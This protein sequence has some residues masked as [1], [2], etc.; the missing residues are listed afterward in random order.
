[1][2]KAMSWDGTGTPPFSLP[3]QSDFRQF[4]SS[5]GIEALTLLQQPE[6]RLDGLPGLEAGQVISENLSIRTNSARAPRAAGCSVN[7]VRWCWSGSS[8]PGRSWGTWRWR[9]GVSGVNLIPV[10]TPS[11][12][13][14]LSN[15][16]KILVQLIEAKRGPRLGQGRPSLA[17]ESFSAQPTPCT[18]SPQLMAS[19]WRGASIPPDVQKS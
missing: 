18:H 16:R 4:S 6:Q 17:R 9:R 10:V 15:P 13:P 19:R 8:R 2:V 5:A 12:R 7:T 11:F 14:R 3:R 1:M